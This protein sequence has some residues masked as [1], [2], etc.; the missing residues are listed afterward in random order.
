MIRMN[1]AKRALETRGMFIQQG[2]GIV[3]G[4]KLFMHA[5]AGKECV[6]RCCWGRAV[7]LSGPDAER[8]GFAAQ[9]TP[10]QCGQ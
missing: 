5:D 2:R 1:C 9:L 4:E 3:N 7:L 10:A 8:P 6:L